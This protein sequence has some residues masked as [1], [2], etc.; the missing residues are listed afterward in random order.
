[1]ALD[2]QQALDQYG[3]VGLLAKSNPELSPLFKKAVDQEWNSARFE[4]EL[5]NTPWWKRLSE[6]KRS[7]AVMRST[8]PA[9]WKTTF[10]SKRS[11]VSALAQRMGLKVD[12]NIWAQQALE[13]DW[14]EAA[15]RAALTYDPRTKNSFSVVNGGLTGEAG[16][17]EGQVK[18]TYAAYGLP[19]SQTRVQ[20]VAQAVMGGRNSIDGIVNETRNLAKKQYSQFAQEIDAGM[21]IREIADPYV[22]T[23]ANV[24]ETPDSE[25]TLND[26]FVRKALQHKGADGKPA[27]MPL[28]EFERQLKDDPRWGQTKQAK[29]ETYALLQQLGKDWGFA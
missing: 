1:M 20:Q 16:Q 15:L 7:I 29:N 23:M 18:E 24:L 28:Y 10:D 17:I 5:A 2:F 13:N 25:I 11:E 12:S 19:V 14:D 4:R 9:T 8:D 27:A 21:T 3:F 26:A 6:R 22:Q